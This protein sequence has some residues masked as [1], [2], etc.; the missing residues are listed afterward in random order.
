MALSSLHTL[1][2]LP[3]AGKRGGTERSAPAQGG[4]G[5]EVKAFP[6]FT[7]RQWRLCSGSEPV[8]LRLPGSQEVYTT[9]LE[10]LRRAV[11]RGRARLRKHFRRRSA[12]GDPE[13]SQRQRQRQRGQPDSYSLTR[14]DFRQ[15]SQRHASM[16]EAVSYLLRRSVPCSSASFTAEARLESRL[17]Q[18]NIHQRPIFGYEQHVFQAVAD[19][20]HFSARAEATES[21]DNFHGTDMRAHSNDGTYHIDVQA[22]RARAG[23]GCAAGCMLVC[24]WVHGWCAA[25]VPLGAA[26]CTAHGAWRDG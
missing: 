6:V 13:A 8:V 22:S 15:H 17:A 24:N 14:A 26:G 1:P 18:T 9:I 10:R 7:D 16:A 4:F 19:D 3:P 20:V 2:A 11:Q 21:L 25:G 23:L 12:D 5:I